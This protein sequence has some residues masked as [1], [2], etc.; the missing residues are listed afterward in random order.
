MVRLREGQEITDF[1]TRY[2]LVLYSKVIMWD[3]ER[4]SPRA[5][6]AY[7]HR[8]CTS[9]VSLAWIWHERLVFTN[10][11]YQLQLMKGFSI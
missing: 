9:L 11:I 1:S 6:S 2:L 5:F 8:H 3:R 10:V 4:T 7:R